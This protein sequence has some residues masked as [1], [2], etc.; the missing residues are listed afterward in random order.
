MHYNSEDAD[1]FTYLADS[2]VFAVKDGYIATPGGECLTFW[3]TPTLALCYLSMVTM[4]TVF[5]PCYVLQPDTTSELMKHC[6]WFQQPN[7]LLTSLNA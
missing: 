6:L 1:L 5:L 2:S 7:R 4:L 3:V